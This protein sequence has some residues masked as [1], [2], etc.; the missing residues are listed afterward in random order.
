LLKTARETL[1][2]V[3]ERLGAPQSKRD[4]LRAAMEKK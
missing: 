4:A 3:Y 2:S 1:M